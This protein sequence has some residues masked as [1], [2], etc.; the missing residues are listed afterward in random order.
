MNKN[1]PLNSQFLHRWEQ[2]KDPEKHRWIGELWM[3]YVDPSDD[4]IDRL[5]IQ[6]VVSK[7]I[8]LSGLKPK[9]VSCVDAEPRF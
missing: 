8:L 9:Q 7:R 3:A 2:A 4:G 1:L 5:M 6:E